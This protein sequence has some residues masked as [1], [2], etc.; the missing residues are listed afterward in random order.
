MLDTLLKLYLPL[1]TVV[2]LG[3]IVVR[4]L[5]AS[6][7]LRIGQFLYYLGIPI[8]IVAFLQ[9]ANLAGKVWLAPIVA[10]GGILGGLTIAWL[11]IKDR[12]WEI[13]SKASFLLAAMVG[14]TGYIGYPV[15]LA[16]GGEKHFAWALFYDLLGTLFGSFGLG[17]VIASQC[18]AKQSYP[19]WRELLQNPTLWSLGLGLILR[20]WSLPTIVLLPLKTIGWG[21]V[22]FS[23]LL[24]GMRLGGVKHL[25]YWGRAWGSV[26]IKMAI[27]PLIFAVVSH[28][29]AIETMPRRI[30][31]LEMAMP[32]AFAT[33]VL[34]EVYELDRELTVSALSVGTILLM[35]TLP[36]WLLL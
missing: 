1:V 32:P 27:V 17:V 23:L 35:F 2:T 10:W 20:R 9:Q 5:P 13:K 30:L 3:V 24:I 31:L 28:F 22:W 12:N 7:P 4:Y 26:V 25:A 29:I 33:V 34:A 16:V 19:W 21:M 36:L 6:V 15:A 11:S 14:N 8:S 18:G